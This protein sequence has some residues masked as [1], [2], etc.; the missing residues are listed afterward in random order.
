MATEPTFSLDADQHRYEAHLDGARIGESD[1]HDDGDTRVITHTEVESEHEGEGI[2][3]HLVKWA[4]DDIRSSGLRVVP[5]CPMVAAY[6]DKHQE[7][8]DL[9]A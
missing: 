1:F 3:S 9:V 2:G 7:Y 8:A 5:Q 6:I 4:L